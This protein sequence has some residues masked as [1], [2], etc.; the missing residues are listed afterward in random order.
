VI[1]ASEGSEIVVPNGDLIAKE[2]KNWTLSAKTARVEILVGTSYDSDPREVLEILTRTAGEHELVAKHPEPSAT[3]YG[4]GD[5]SLDFRLFCHTT[6]DKRLD[7][8]SD[9]LVKI[10]EALSDVGITIPFPQ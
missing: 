6:V 1:Q 3:M 8:T 7:V 9:L 10:F 5:S 4:F 2:V